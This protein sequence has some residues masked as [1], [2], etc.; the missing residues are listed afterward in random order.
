MF[1]GVT[2][3]ASGIEV[4]SERQFCQ[5]SYLFP[6]YCSRRGNVHRHKPKVLYV[7]YIVSVLVMANVVV[8]DKQLEYPLFMEHRKL[9]FIRVRVPGLLCVVQQKCLVDVVDVGSVVLVVYQH[10]RFWSSCQFPMLVMSLF[11]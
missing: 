7:N 1:H 5:R 8:S 11:S 6:I 2:A 4:Y 3:E 9:R 10:L